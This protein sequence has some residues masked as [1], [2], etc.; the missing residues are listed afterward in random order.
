MKL[1]KLGLA[2]STIIVMALTTAAGLQNAGARDLG[3]GDRAWTGTGHAVDVQG[4]N[5]GGGVFSRKASGNGEGSSTV[6]R[7]WKGNKG[8]TA[9][10]ATNRQWNRQTHSL[11]R[12]TTGVGPTGGAWSGNTTDTKTATGLT[13]GGNWTGPKGDTISD[14]GTITKTANGWTNQGTWTGPNGKTEN[15]YKTV[16]KTDDGYTHDNT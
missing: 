11:T 6:N 2:A 16:T 5:C 13:H 7:S 8:G 10:S 4:S 15:Y 9:S 1:G 14:N 3:E 12:A